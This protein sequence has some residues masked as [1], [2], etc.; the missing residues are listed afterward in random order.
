MINDIK[1]NGIFV[2]NT[3]KTPDELDGFLPN[4]VKNVIN[5]R[6]V[7][8]YIIDADK[9]AMDAGIKG[10]ISKIMQMVIMSLLDY[11]DAMDVIGKSIEKQFA[12]KGDEVINANKKA[13]TLAM[14]SLV[15]VETKLT[16]VEENVKVE[17]NIFD[18]I[19]ARRG[20]D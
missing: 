4:K 7:K 18:E 19:N 5:E 11:P 12:T 15:L 13:I 10:K 3:T 17:K 20:D 1:E 14:D 6:N 2:L 16:V 8:L 9:I